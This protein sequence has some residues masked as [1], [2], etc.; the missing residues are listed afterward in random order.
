MCCTS[1]FHT[2]LL[3]CRYTIN[4]PG[5]E[6]FVIDFAIDVCIDSGCKVVQLLSQQMVPIPFCYTNGT[7]SL[8]GGSLDGYLRQ[9]AG[10]IV[11]ENIDLVLNTLGVKVS[12]H[13]S[14]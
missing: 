3:Y 13:V 5:D 11:E 7:L 4:K 8:P 10:N 14:P 1:K 6:F 2:L 12:V 9:L